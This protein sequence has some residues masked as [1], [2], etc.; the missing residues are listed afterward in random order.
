[1]NTLMPFKRGC[2][3]GWGMKEEVRKLTWHDN[4]VAALATVPVLSGSALAAHDLAVI[5]GAEGLRSQRLVALGA[6]ETAL[7]PVAVLVVQFLDTGREVC[8]EWKPSSAEFSRTLY[9]SGV[10]VVSS[11]ALGLQARK[12]SAPTWTVES[13]EPDRGS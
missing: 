2:R 4:L 5:S 12:R 1:M 9:Q 3:T 11:C 13:Q 7:V 10:F 8:G 6:A